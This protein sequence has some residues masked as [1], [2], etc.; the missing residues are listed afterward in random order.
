MVYFSL[1]DSTQKWAIEHP[2]TAATGNFIADAAIAGLESRASGDIFG[3]LKNQTGEEAVEHTPVR[4]YIEQQPIRGNTSPTSQ[5]YITS[6]KIST[7]ISSSSRMGEYRNRTLNSSYDYN[8]EV[9]AGICWPLER[10]ISN[11]I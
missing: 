7:R 10:R 9:A 11:K 6:S 1:S 4:G 2:K 3:G 5:K 8:P